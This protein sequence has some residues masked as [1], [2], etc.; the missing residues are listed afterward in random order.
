[1]N[2]LFFHGAF[3]L[4]AAAITWMASTFVGNN[5]LALTVTLI[6]GCV[7][8]IGFAELLQFRGA[9][10]SLSWALSRIDDTVSRDSTLFQQWVAQLHPSLQNAVR[11][12]IEG[13]RVGLPAPAITPYLVGLLIMLGLLGTFVGMVETL[14]GAVL[15]LE[16]TTELQAIRAGLA[17]PIQGLS[18]AFGTSVAGVAA[19]AMLGLVST[20]SRR[21]RMLATRALDGKIATVFRPLSLDYQ[22]RESYKALQLQAQAIPD[23]A[24][25]L[26]TLAEQL[27]LMGDALGEK[28][29][30]SQQ[31]FHQSTESAYQNL[32]ASVDASLKES[33]A[34]SGRLAGESM[35][36]VVAQ[37]MAGITEATQRVH[38]ALTE[39]T[40]TQLEK[41]TATLA[42]QLSTLR[43][44]EER[45]GNAAIERLG[46]LEVIVATQ[47]AT[48]GT[49]L[50]EPM[51][52]LIDSAAQAPQAAAEVIA[53]LRQEISNTAERDNVLLEERQRLMEQLGSLSSALERSSQGQRETLESML[54]SSTDLLRKASGHF[55]EKVDV[56]VTEMSEV[57]QQFAGGATEMASL[58]EAFTVAVGL[59]NES[60]GLL[61]DKLSRIEESLDKAN[62]R[63][64]EQMGY[65]VAQARQIIDQSML[66]QR[67]MFE[68][69]R[70]L[71]QRDLLE[72]V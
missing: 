57:A 9:T 34:H 23:V 53:Q 37:A 38:R 59:F 4:G 8:A 24:R 45:R 52:R 12:R 29:Q 16:G 14:S 13:E 22:R 26:N 30:A 47:L 27:A 21:D 42:A 55:S 7:Y 43:E 32:A 40:Q 2:K 54:S 10:S 5:S 11:Q 39:T 33:L 35:Q 46:A 1:M 62:T 36:G 17:A 63:S 15:A 31:A 68:E 49:A 19:S 66:S 65:Y 48:L 69:L 25:T 70:Q 64:D 3:F 58:G 60:N 20:L 6:I 50:E 51:V 56:H 41:L 72:Q 61:I 18:V 28:L 44:Q 67:E 71:G